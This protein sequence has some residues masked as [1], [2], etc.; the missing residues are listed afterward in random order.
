MDFKT[1]VVSEAEIISGF[2]YSDVEIGKFIG[3]D[4]FKRSS[5]KIPR[6]AKAMT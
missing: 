3:L 2:C 5:M 6:E 4:I 1:W